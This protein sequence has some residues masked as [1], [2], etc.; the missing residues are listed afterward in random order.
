MSQFTH[1]FAYLVCTL[2]ISASAQGINSSPN[3]VTVVNLLFYKAASKAVFA[4]EAVL[5]HGK[6]V[7]RCAMVEV[8]ELS[9]MTSSE[10][11]QLVLF[12]VSLD[13]VTGV[14]EASCMCRNNSLC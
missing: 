4:S 5:Y 11:L 6:V 3:L 8:G 14:S 7:W 10:T 9:V 12:A 2:I 1:I 13:S